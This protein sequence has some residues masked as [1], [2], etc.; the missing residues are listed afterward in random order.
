MQRRISLAGGWSGTSGRGYVVI[1][2]L[3]TIIAS[4]CSD[5]NNS[6]APLTAT[7]ITTNASTNG[8]SGGAGTALAQPVGVTVFDQNGAALANATV[9]WAVESGAGSVASATSVTD[10]SGNATIVWT[11]GPTLGTDSLK[12]SI[13]GGADAFVLATVV[14]GPASAVHVTSGDPQSVTA[15][16]ATAPLVVQVVDQFANPVPNVTVTWAVAGGGTL[17]ATSTTTDATGSTQVTLTTDASP[18]S[19]TVSATAGTITPVTFTI[20]AN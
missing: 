18:A 4:A 1:A 3:A 12:A 17:S 16:S 2:A 8:Q 15:G 10:A 14:P 9:N 11:L 6:T 20:T 13:A 5:N 7:T 19:Y